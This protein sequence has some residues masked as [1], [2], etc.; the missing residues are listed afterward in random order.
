MSGMMIL[1]P[2][3][4]RLGACK[5]GARWREIAHLARLDYTTVSRIY[6]GRSVPS[7]LVAERILNAMDVLDAAQAAKDALDAAKAEKAAKA[8][9]AEVQAR[10]AAERAAERAS[11]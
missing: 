4:A 3:K 6:C 7:V 10:L 8:L 11:A 2:M 1:E 9:E 5:H